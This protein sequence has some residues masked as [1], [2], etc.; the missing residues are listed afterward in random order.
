MGAWIETLTASR[1]KVSL[2]VAPFVGA[3]I[4]TRYNIIKKEG[5]NVAPFVGAWIET[6]IAA[7]TAAA[8]AASLPS[9]ERGLKQEN[10]KPQP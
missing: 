10:G 6:E 9:W 7:L 5:S 2:N 1:L 3:W 4:E 8:F